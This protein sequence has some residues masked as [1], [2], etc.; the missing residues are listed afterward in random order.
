MGSQSH[1]KIEIGWSKN[2]D[3]YLFWVKDNGMGIKRE[4][5]EKIFNVFYRGSGVSKEGTG[6]GLSIAK[7][8]IENHGGKIWVKSR[9]GRGSTFYFTIPIQ[10][11][12]LQR[13]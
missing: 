9:P 7:K 6:I 13:S 2:K 5:H 1:P 4:D 8:V 3:H 10:E 12:S 11:S